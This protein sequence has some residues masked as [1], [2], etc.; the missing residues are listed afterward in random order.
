MTMNE[1][2]KEHR[3]ALAAGILAACP[4][5]D[6]DTDEIENWILNDGSLYDWAASEGV[7]DI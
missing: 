2:I 4:N 1:F 7:T 6:I 5:C 3:E